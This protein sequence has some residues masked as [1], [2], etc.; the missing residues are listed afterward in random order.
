MKGS[1]KKGGQPL[2]LMKYL[3]FIVLCVFILIKK[4]MLCGL[5]LFS[6]VTVLFSYFMKN[7]ANLF[8]MS[9]LSMKYEH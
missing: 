4:F 6:I 3:S 7:V 1:E 9:L 5:I 2:F 8:V